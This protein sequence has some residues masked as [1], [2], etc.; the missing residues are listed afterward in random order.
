M[1]DRTPISKF[2]NKSLESYTEFE[3]RWTD[4]FA[5]FLTKSFGTLRF[6]ILTLIFII[7]WII[8][9][10]GLI[11][12]ISP[13]D[14]YPFVW[15]VTLV[16]LFSIILSITILISQ[17]QEERINEV[18]QQMDFEINVRAEQEITKILQM[19]AEIHSKLGIAKLDQELEQMKESISIS[20]IKEDVEQGIEDKNKTSGIT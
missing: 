19:I 10:L 1:S 4:A 11:P 12:G 14:L 3:E 6:L 16:Q 8:I 9:N 5:K 2:L 7:L 15:L 20:E 13:F 17:N 18:R